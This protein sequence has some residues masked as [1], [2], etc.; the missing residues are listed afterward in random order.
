MIFC[1]KPGAFYYALGNIRPEN[2]S[3][4][5]AI[6]LLALVNSKHLKTYGVD[7]ILSAFMND[8]QLLEQVCN[9]ICINC[10]KLHF[11]KHLGDSGQ[12]QKIIIPCKLINI[13]VVLE[14][15]FQQSRK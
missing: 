12:D 2:R 1:L 10:L 8:L 14:Y 5:N 3:H 11:F 13:K 15:I 6:Q 7:T 9:N 4:M